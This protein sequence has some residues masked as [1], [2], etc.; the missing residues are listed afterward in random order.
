MIKRILSLSLT[1]ML[2][3]SLLVGCAPNNKT[4]GANAP[5]GANGGIVDRNDTN[6][7]LPNDGVTG[8]NKVLPNDG[9]TGDNKAIPNDG[10]TANELAPNTAVR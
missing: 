8:D 5:D 2:A 6:D 10:V 3:L 9:V 1:L 4:P 7:V